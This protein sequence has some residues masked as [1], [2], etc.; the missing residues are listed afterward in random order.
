MSAGNVDKLAKLHQ[1]LDDF[2]DRVGPD[3][4]IN[5]LRPKYDVHVYMCLRKRQRHEYKV[6]IYLPAL[7]C[8]ESF[9]LYQ[10]NILYVMYASYVIV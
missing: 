5:E 7:I 9:Q 4:L 6:S 2:V 1:K 3:V 10:F 8:S